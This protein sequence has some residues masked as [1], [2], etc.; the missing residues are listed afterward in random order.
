MKLVT[1]ILAIIAFSCTVTQSDQSNDSINSN[2]IS[3][4]LII[5]KND[6]LQLAQLIASKNNEYLEEHKDVGKDKGPYYDG[7]FK[8][9]SDSLFLCLTLKGEYSGGATYNPFSESYIVKDEKVLSE[10][11]DGSIF[12]ID[13]LKVNEY[14]LYADAYD[15]LGSIVNLYHLN[16]VNDTAI[17]K[18]AKK[19]DYGN[20]YFDFISQKNEHPSLMKIKIDIKNWNDENTLRTLKLNSNNI[21]SNVYYKLANTSESFND[22]HISELDR[23]GRSSRLNFIA[24]YRH[25][26]GDQLEKIVRIE[27][28]DRSHDLVLCM[29]GGDSFTQRI[30]T[31]F[32]NDSIFKETFVTIQSNHETGNDLEEVVDSVVTTSK[33]NKSFEFTEVKRDSIHFIK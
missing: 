11:I 31:Q 25:S 21:A 30:S 17:T 20:Y 10:P 8:Y 12:R 2:K 7:S 32:V 14:I 28:K 22:F 13:K 6:S 9:P 26:Y 19:E 24:Y 27:S 16:I 18:A 3:P 23:T 5:N 4:D 33:Y 1:F 15:R 29:E